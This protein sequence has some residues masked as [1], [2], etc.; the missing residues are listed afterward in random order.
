MDSTLKNEY[1]TPGLVL[2]MFAAGATLFGV[3]IFYLALSDVGAL[4]MLL[5]EDGRYSWSGGTVD[6]VDEPGTKSANEP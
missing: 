3:S 2:F 1:F 6:R 4:D 5:F